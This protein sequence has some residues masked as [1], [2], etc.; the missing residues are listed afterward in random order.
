MN[1]PQ[2]NPGP[3]R[4]DRP[5]ALCVSNLNEEVPDQDVREALKSEFGRFGEFRIQIVQKGDRR[6]SYLNFFHPEDAITA[7]NECGKV[8]LFDK[9][10]H[11]E[12]VPPKKRNRSP[13]PGERRERFRGGSPGWRGSGFGDGPRE[14]HGGRRHSGD[15]FPH[16]LQ[17]V[18]PE[19]DPEATR[20]LFVGNLE[21]EIDE[22]EIFMVFERFGEMEDIDVKH[23]QRGGGNAYA[24]IKF[25]NLDMAHRAKVEL[26]G[27]LI[28]KLPCKIGYGKVTPSKCIWVGGLGP[29]VRIEKLEREFDRFGVINAIEWPAGKTY[30]YV[31]YNNIEAA[32]AACTEMRG[33][34]MDGP[35]H[36]LRVD[37]A[38]EAYIE[39]EAA[40]PVEMKPRGYSSSRSGIEE[41]DPGWREAPGRA[42][43]DIR[44]SWGSGEGIATAD[45]AL[46]R[47][48]RIS[49]SPPPR[50]RRYEEGR[51][52]GE[53]SSYYRGSR[54]PER[55][56]GRGNGHFHS[57]SVKRRR[58]NSPDISPRAGSGEVEPRMRGPDDNG[59]V[60][61]VNTV[62]DLAKCIPC[63]WSGAVILKNSAFAARMHMLSG[64]VD[65]VDNLMRDPTSTEMP[66]LRVM[67]RLR[68]D[69]SKLEE[70]AR[71]VSLSGRRGN[72]VLLAMPGNAQALEESN[73]NIQQRPLRNLVSYLKQ[74]DAA[75]VIT[76][77]PHLSA[78]EK[79]GGILY[80]FPP[81]QFAFE[82]ILKKAPHM[83]KIESSKEEYLVVVVVVSD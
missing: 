50:R 2:R 75:G 69:Q 71:R 34:P 61:D 7:I 66:V 29:W 37:F 23:P 26:S 20:T 64:D 45:R 36:R 28:G 46:S 13:S 4:G 55:E 14:F 3:P 41:V 56:M 54:S 68:L 60:L 5:N 83:L 48:K 8:I 73:T 58:G 81:C 38:D 25:K 19:D 47:E 70:V 77:P 32:Q 52:R 79:E 24:F 21:P 74:K 18:P 22:K 42:R 15:R 63:V 72:S 62:H 35:D 12:I 53:R 11:I 33:F 82:M 49:N 78:K 40:P 27:E 10:V 6:L 39:E 80:A 16:H 43:V 59:C 1:G 44:R 31:L 67:Q 51:E 57:P 9:P 65:L 76:L 30:A 17:H